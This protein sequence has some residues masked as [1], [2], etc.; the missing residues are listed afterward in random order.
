MHNFYESGDTMSKMFEAEEMMMLLHAMEG[1]NFSLENLGKAGH[2]KFPKY[3]LM[4]KEMLPDRTSWEKLGFSF[5]DMMGDTVL[6]KALMPKGWRIEATNH[7]MWSNIY[8]DKDNLR[9]EMFYKD[10]SRDREAHMSLI[11][12]YAI[13]KEYIDE[14]RTTC[15]IYF[16]NPIEKIFVAGTVSIPS[17]STREERWAKYN[18]EDKLM[19]IVKVFADENYPG[20][21][22]VLAYWD[23]ELED[24]V[25]TIKK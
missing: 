2:N 7:S 15:E 21:E 16:G 14:D 9:G 22:N 4:A 23:D 5:M 13:H 3:H 17:N 24:T 19:N 8:D 18:E 20:W 25:G 11:R 1:E 12:R 10:S 6:C